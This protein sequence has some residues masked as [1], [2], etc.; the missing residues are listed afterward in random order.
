MFKNL[1]ACFL[2]V[3][4]R[5][6]F[7]AGKPSNDTASFVYQCGIDFQRALDAYYAEKAST[8]QNL[9]LIGDVS[10]SI[11]N[12]VYQMPTALAEAFKDGEKDCFIKS[13]AA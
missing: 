1:L 8:G 6:T 3:E 4:K 7:V 5:L 2:D 9:G 12:I 10:E 11:R 13:L